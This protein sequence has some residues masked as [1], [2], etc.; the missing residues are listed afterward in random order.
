MAINGCIWVR[1]WVFAR[2][3]LRKIKHFSPKLKVSYHNCAN[4]GQRWQGN[5]R[6]LQKLQG[7]QRAVQKTND[8]DSQ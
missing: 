4:E 8:L 5:G 3:G 2:P 6:E 7:S 1:I